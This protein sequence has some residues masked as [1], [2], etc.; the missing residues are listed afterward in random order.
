MFKKWVFIFLILI[1]VNGCSNSLEGPFKVTKVVD[2]D[3]LDLNNSQRVRFS[4]INT[5][6]TGECYYQEAKD[7]LTKMVLEKDVFLEKDKSNVGKYGRLLRYVYMDNKL[8]NA[9]LVEEGYAR[10]FDKYKEDTKKYKELKELESIAKANKAGLWSC[11]DSKNDC[12]YVGSKNSNTYHDPDC[13]FAKKIK[14]ENL[15]CYK[16]DLEVEGLNPCKTCVNYSGLK[17]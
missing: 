8:I 4:G 3:T 17:P 7:K 14:P 15:V 10:V 5:P 16:T 13:K 9:F 1:L 12:L 2:G 11:T 6:E